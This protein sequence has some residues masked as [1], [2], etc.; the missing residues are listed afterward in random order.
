MKSFLLKVLVRPLQVFVYRFGIA[1]NWSALSS[2]GNSRAAKLTILMPIVGYLIIF[3]SATS[4]FLATSLPRRAEANAGDALEFLYSKNMFFLYFGLLVFGLGV[5][6]YNVAVPRQI[7]RYPSVEDYISTMETIGTRNLVTGSFDNVVGM[8]F[9]NLQGEER[10]SMYSHN[11]ISFPSSVSGNFHRLVEEM[12]LEVDPEV[13]DDGVPTEDS[14][15]LARRFWTGSGFL[16]TEEVIEVMYSGRRMDRVLLYAMYAEAAKRAKDVF[17][18]EHSALEFSSPKVRFL[19]FLF[20][21]V[22]LILTTLP[23]VFTS[24]M[25][26]RHW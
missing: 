21:S 17:Y 12:F 3:N 6:L 13:W 22:G 18:I 5:A 11:N 20:Y 1:I 15:L 26:I 25:I 16:M 24:G 4:E 23:S 7:S 8:Y 14:P 10:S 19:V 9:D 2:I